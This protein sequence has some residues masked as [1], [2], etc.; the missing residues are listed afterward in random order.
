MLW[1][2]SMIVCCLDGIGLLTPLLPDGEHGIL[3]GESELMEA[4]GDVA[5]VPS[6]DKVDGQLVVAQVVVPRIVEVLLEGVE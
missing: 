1:V 6:V 3:G 4:L 5:I 2:E